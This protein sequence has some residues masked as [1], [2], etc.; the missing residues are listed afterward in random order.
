MAL[1]GV[2]IFDSSG[3]VIQTSTA[4]HANITTI[5]ATIASV[6]FLSINPARSGFIVNNNSNAPLQVACSVT[7]SSVSYSASL[8]PNG[9]FTVPNPVDYTGVVSGLWLATP[10][11]TGSA[12][13]TEFTP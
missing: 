6:A 4:S 13:I 7:A 9:T 11:P 2:S 5:P 10:A 1:P 12:V 3:N 8:G